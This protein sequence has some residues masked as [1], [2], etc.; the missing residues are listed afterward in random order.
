MESGRNGQFFAWHGPALLNVDQLSHTH[1]SL[2][3]IPWHTIAPP[4]RSLVRSTEASNDDNGGKVFQIPRSRHGH[5]SVSR[6]R[7]R[8][9][10]FFFFRGEHT[11]TAFR[12]VGG[13]EGGSG[14]SMLGAIF[15]F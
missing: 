4:L 12:S 2:Q 6:P 14:R 9:V 3:D 7:R 11:A 5:P 10:L 1:S 8:P 15:G 13:G